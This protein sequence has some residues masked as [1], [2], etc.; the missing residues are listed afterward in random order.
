MK[1]QIT[2]NPTIHKMTMKGFFSSVL[3]GSRY[4][5]LYPR[6]VK[7]NTVSKVR[8][9]INKTKPFSVER[10]IADALNDLAFGYETVEKELN[11][12]ELN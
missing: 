4:I 5:S 12:A 1:N 7:I 2:Y 10:N 11:E 3:C 8:K 6:E 9:Y